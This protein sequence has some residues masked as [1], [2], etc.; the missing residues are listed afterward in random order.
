MTIVNISVAFIL[1][2]AGRVLYMHN[3]N[4]TLTLVLWR[5][6]HYYLKTW[7]LNTLPA[8][9]TANKWQRLMQ[10]RCVWLQSLWLLNAVS[11]CLMQCL[12]LNR[13]SVHVNNTSSPSPTKHTHV[14]THLLALRQLYPRHKMLKLSVH[15]PPTLP[16]FQLS[17]T[18]YS[19]SFTVY[20]G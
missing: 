4:L 14:H 15:S 18:H 13:L 11:S 19:V 7:N 20:S 6:F 2:Q 16:G 3:L 17:V 5:R 8:C 12:L 10:T 9:Y 1:C